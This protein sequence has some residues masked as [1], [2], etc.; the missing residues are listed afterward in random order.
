MIN[1]GSCGHIVQRG[2]FHQQ[3]D[4]TITGYKYIYVT[5]YK[6]KWIYDTI[7]FYNK[8]YTSYYYEAFY[9]KGQA[10]LTKEIRKSDT[11]L[12]TDRTNWEKQVNLG[13]EKQPPLYLNT[14]PTLADKLE[15][16]GTKYT[17]D[18][19]KYV[20]VGRVSKNGLHPQNGL[21]SS[22]TYI[23]QRGYLKIQCYSI[24]RRTRDL[25]ISSVP[26][27]RYSTIPKDLDNIKVIPDTGVANKLFDMLP[28]SLLNSK[29]CFFQF[30]S[31][32]CKKSGI[33]INPECTI[34][35]IGIKFRDG[36][37]K[38]WYYNICLLPNARKFTGYD[39][40]PWMKK[41]I[42]DLHLLSSLPLSN[43]EENID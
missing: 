16:D 25:F 34:H 1:R 27:L 4:T 40:L 36:S 22:Y 39:H 29:S 9:Y 38:T 19:V 30:D 21:D 33:L 10:R 6:N 28:D 23:D 42:E 15:V 31:I 20:L 14:Y 12:I 2:F 8:N 24:S 32:A 43:R 5:P 11:L 7:P 3:P 18:D 26:D 13:L 37:Y 17:V 41:L 35:N